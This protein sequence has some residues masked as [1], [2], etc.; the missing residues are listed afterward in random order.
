MSNYDST[1]LL[2]LIL[3]LSMSLSLPLTFLTLLSVLPLLST[4]DPLIALWIPYDLPM[5]PASVNPIELKLFDGTSNSVIT[6]LVTSTYHFL[7][8]GLGKCLQSYFFA[9]K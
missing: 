5:T 6:Q 4:L 9:T 2:F 1:Q 7:S 3:A 8:F